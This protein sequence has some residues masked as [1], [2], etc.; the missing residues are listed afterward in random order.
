MNTTRIELPHL[1]CTVEGGYA[2]DVAAIIQ[3]NLPGPRAVTRDT[4]HSSREQAAPACNEEALPMPTM[5]WDDLRHVSGPTPA[6]L[7]KDS[8]PEP[9]TDPSPRVANYSGLGPVPGDNEE[10]LEMPAMNFAKSET[11]AAPHTGKPGLPIG[12]TA[13]ATPSVVR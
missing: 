9:Q 7:A 8:M 11:Y 2:Q 6:E 4:S 12:E 1:C 10:V 5:N 3:K 13:M